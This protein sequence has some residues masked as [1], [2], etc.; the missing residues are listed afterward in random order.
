MGR[1]IFLYLLAVNIITFIVFGIDKQRAKNH[2]WR[3]S[4]ATLIGF[5]VIGGSVGALVGMRFF[6]HKTKHKKFT[7]GIPVI[8]MIQAVA[9][10]IF[11]V[12]LRKGL[13]LN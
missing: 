1:M 3:I 12:A 7:V 9:P 10:V 8:L 5:A 6:R 2:E 11:M 4:E 13:M